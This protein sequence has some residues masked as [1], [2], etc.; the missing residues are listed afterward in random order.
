MKNDMKK[1]NSEKSKKFWEDKLKTLGYK[2][3]KPRKAIINVLSRNSNLYKADDIYFMVKKEHPEIGIA[4][5][6]RTLE[7]LSRLNLICKIS[8]GS[9]KSYYMLSRNCKKETMV[10]MICDKCGTIIVNNKCL[11]SAIRIRMID[12][13]EKHIFKNCKLKIDKYQIFFSGICDKCL[14]K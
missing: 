7:L 12:D 11:N 3:T 9:D 5:V 8:L 6:Y 14:T 1:T 10:Y 2:S 4:T 13:A